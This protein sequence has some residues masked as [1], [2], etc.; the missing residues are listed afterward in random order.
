[1]RVSAQL[2]DAGSGTQLWA[3]SFDR[4]FGDVLNL[5][6]DV[7]SGIARALQLAVVAE[8][9]RPHRSLQ[10]TEAY[11]HYLRGRAALDRGN[12][13]SLPESVE[14]LRQALILDPGFTRAAEALMLA[15]LAILGNSGVPSKIGWP[16]IAISAR[17]A[18]QLDPQSALAHAILGLQ[19][20]TY[21]YNWAAADAELRR[22]LALDTRDPVALYNLSW[23]AFDLGRHEESLRLQN[24]SVSIDPL[25]PDAYQNGAIINY[26][27]GN[28]DAAERGLR[29]SVR[30]SPTFQANHWYLGQV[31]LQR[32]DAKG[33]LKEMLQETSSVRDVGLALAYH[34]LGRKAESDAALARGTRSTGKEA[35]MNIAIAHA[36]RGER[37]EAF[38]WLEKAIDERDLLVG[39][40]FWDEPKLEP[41]RSDPRYKALL[42]KVNRPAPNS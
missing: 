27:L 12:P 33:A 39:H 3:D 13:E 34:A 17:R 38:V 29:T 41:L 31:C 35:P 6:D 30:I 15:Q 16:A 4:A 42:A 37:D 8:D 1:M 14:E 9:A 28:L 22:A 10:S 40:K 25:N 19:Y 18:L 26:L 7:A 11:T 5:Q 20:A 21:E 23:L 32:G 2:I 36:Y 24:L